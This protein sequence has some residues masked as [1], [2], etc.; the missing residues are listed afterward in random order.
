M[1]TAEADMAEAAAFAVRVDRERA[2]ATSP[3]QLHNLDP[4]VVLQRP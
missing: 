3:P 1:D 2:A 4:S